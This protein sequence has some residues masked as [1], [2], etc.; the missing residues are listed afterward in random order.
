[1]AFKIQARVEGL[2]GVLKALGALDKK[3]RKKGVRKMASA[4]GGVV[5]KRAR[6]LVPRDTGLLK[7]SL[8]R[9]VKAYARTG[10][11]V[12][13]VG[14]RNDPKFRQQVTRAKG[15]K[16][17]RTLLANP[18]RYAHLV[19]GGTQLA[20]PHPFLAPAVGG[21]QSAVR[22]AMARAA[23]SVIQEAP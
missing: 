7:K 10:V 21:Q 9:K 11:A 17:P 2:D 8:G 20:P 14:P 12:A 5:L 18:V 22:E 23:L 19:E 13:V 6:Q 15:R 16:R 3:L 4:G 1:M